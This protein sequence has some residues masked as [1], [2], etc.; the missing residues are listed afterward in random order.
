VILS[1][2][3]P[4]RIDLAGGTLDLWP[5]CH[6]LDRPAVTV[7]LA[8]DLRARVDVEERE[9]QRLEIVSKDRGESVL[10]PLSHLRHDRLGLATRL[11]EHFGAGRGL[12]VTMESAA[13]PQSGLGGSSCL[14]IAL[15][16]ALARLRGYA[17][18]PQDLRALVQNV[19]AAVLG[20]PAGYQDYIPPLFGGLNVIVATPAGLEVSTDR[21][22]VDFFRGRLLLADTAIPHQSGLNNW[23]VFRAFI[24]RDA[25][26]RAALNAIN[27]CATRMRAAVEARDLRAVGAALREEW[28][29]RRKLSPVVSNAKIDAIEAAAMRA[30]A[31]G[32]KICG[33]GGGGCLAIVAESP[34]AILPAIAAAGAKAVPFSPDPR[35]VAVEEIRA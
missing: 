19:E 23:E 4:C 14:A 15:A 35:G 22:A 33:A 34:E 10:L 3:A 9:D 25:K 13:P 21:G 1:A 24:D 20:T 17:G 12:K 28:A 8:I 30:G 26:V 5:I 2:S 31:L 11:V 18:G 32:A 27:R 29:E 16:A 7:N 6:L